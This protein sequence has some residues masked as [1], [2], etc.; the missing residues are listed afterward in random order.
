MCLRGCSIAVVVLSVSAVCFAGN[1]VKPTTTLSALTNNNTSAANNFPNQSNGNLGA[2]NISKV[3]I[4]SL[5]YPGATTKIYAHLLLWFG[6]SNH[7]NIDYSSTD[8]NQ[9]HNQIEDMI[10]R[11]IDGVIIDWY[12]PGNSM[13][14]AT[15]LVMAEAEKHPGFTFAIMIDQGAIEWDS[16]SGCSPQ[17]ALVSQLQYLEKTYFPSN[18]YMTIAGHPVV[19]NFNIDLS[20]SVDWNAANAALSSHPAFLFQNNNGFT[21][22]LADGS[23]SWVMPT[24]NDYGMS[25][26][27]SFYDT[28]TP[29][30]SEQT[31]GATYKGFN[32]TLASWGSD[33]IMQQ[34]CGQTWLETFSE[35]NRLYNSG[36]QLPYLQLVT[37]NDYEEA[38]EIESGIDDC[39]S[40]S[41]SVSSNGLKWQL[42][43]SESAVDHL[44]IFIS[45]DGE[46]LMQL[47]EMQPG[48]T[49][50]N[51]CSYPIPAGNYRLFVQAVGKPTLDN[52]ITGAINYSPTCNAGTGSAGGVSLTATPASQTIQPGASGSF[53][54]TAAAQSGSFGSPIALSC[55]NLPSVLTCSFSPASVTPNAGSVSSVLTISAANLGAHLQQGRIRSWLYAGWILPFGVGFTFITPKRRRRVARTLAILGAVGITLLL[56]SCGGSSSKTP[57][58]TVAPIYSIT[59]TGSSGSTQLSSTI[60]VTVP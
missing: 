24:T 25:Y 6:E 57:A 22:T 42:G 1:Y 13:D 45:T 34:Q 12:G 20:Y 31:V 16:C 55:T 56:A 14:Q 36:K 37:W 28:G 50:L 11:G 4:H 52:R 2:A 29:Y 40:V 7:M 9:I 15:Q 54:I 8:P 38:T 48:T 26:L 23:Y 41:A 21:H 30:P 5:L 10:S 27:T 3:D 53:T 47:A 32:D 33:R 35:I 18:A 39:V 46:N 58:N 43:G 44:S 51:L 49:S 19:T 60:T 17:Q 59:V